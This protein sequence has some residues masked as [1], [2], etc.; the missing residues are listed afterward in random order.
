MGDHLYDTSPHLFASLMM[1]VTT[2]SGG[3][4]RNVRHK[5]RQ[6]TIFCGHVAPQNNEFEVAL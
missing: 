2:F 1:V 4:N 3:G 6:C 5:K